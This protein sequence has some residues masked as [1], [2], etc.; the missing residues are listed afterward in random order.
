MSSPLS[1]FPLYASLHGTQGIHQKHKSEHASPLPQTIQ[2]ASIP[3]RIK[4]KVC[5]SYRLRG[6]SPLPA[7]SP[8]VPCIPAPP[9][10]PNSLNVLCLSQ[11]WASFSSHSTSTW[12]AAAS[13]ARRSLSILGRFLCFPEIYTCPPLGLLNTQDTFLLFSHNRP[14][15]VYILSS[16]WAPSG[17]ESCLTRISES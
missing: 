15:F 5:S 6:L 2:W 4:P 8:C 17:Q 12:R 14:L 3:C 16:L 10:V 13:P 9:R 1:Q 11:H 7:D